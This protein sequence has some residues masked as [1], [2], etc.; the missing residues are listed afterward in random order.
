MNRSF[1]TIATGFLLASSGCNVESHVA[2]SGADA[3]GPSTAGSVAITTPLDSCDDPDQEPEIA[4][5][6][7]I[8]AFT[9]R[10]GSDR[11]RVQIEPDGA[12]G[13]GGFLLAGEGPHIE[14]IPRTPDDCAF[15]C[16]GPIDESIFGATI[17]GFR[18]SLRDVIHT[19]NRLRF[20]I[21]HNEIFAAWCEAQ[22][23][24]ADE[25]NA[26]RYACIPNTGGAYDWSTYE[27]EL[28]PDGE[29]PIPVPCC[30]MTLCDFVCECTAEGCI[31]RSDGETF[32]FFIEGDVASG[33]TPF[34]T[35]HLE[36]VAP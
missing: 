4:W 8:E 33:T 17:E 31:A 11:V 10:S 25:V 18:Y 35:G 7:W 23:P 9:F 22:A 21:D 19:D 13:F 34:G 24:V 28:H 26:G 3:G 36:R 27:C 20:E 1:L 6:G 15:L 14:G 30:R 29:A 12:G 2:T 5:D 16:T 32:D